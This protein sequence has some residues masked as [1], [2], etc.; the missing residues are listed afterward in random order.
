MRK[1]N[2]I[3]GI[4][5]LAVVFF[6]DAYAALTCVSEEIVA[7]VNSDVITKKDLTDFTNFMRMQMAQAGMKSE[8]EKKA[9]ELKKDMLNKLIDDRLILQE[10]KKAEIKVDE[11]KIKDR[12]KEIKKNYATEGEFV[13]ELLK[14]GITEADIE[15]RVREQFL[16]H[17]VVQSKIRN[18]IKI[19][20]DEVTDFYNK[21]TLDFL[22]PG[23]RVYQMVSSTT[24]AG[25]KMAA[26]AMKE[27]DPLEPL[28]VKYELKIGSIEVERESALRK[29]L[30]EAVAS[31]IPGGVSEPVNVDNK[32][33]VFKLETMEPSRQQTLAE[34]QDDITEF[35]YDQKMQGEMVKWIDE[36]KANSYIKICQ[37]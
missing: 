31:L 11:S 1:S 13:A 27:G 17:N 25:A 6:S 20:P 5:L 7:V 32:F 30:E 22:V 10:A 35:L 18:K 4:A 24:E 3:L 23:R 12:M 9:Q 36:L 34:V 26:K 15:N 21:H 28:V 37:N 2:I 8:S 16:M 29:E 19:R 14:Q 33:L